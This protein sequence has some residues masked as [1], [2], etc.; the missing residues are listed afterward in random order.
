MAKN[1]GKKQVP[2]VGNIY[3]EIHKIDIETMTVILAGGFGL[4]GNLA[5]AYISEK[6]PKLVFVGFLLFWVLVVVAILWIRRST[7]KTH[8][9]LGA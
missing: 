8:P 2:L 4:L 6:D 3:T 7:F 9:K 1:L 5:A